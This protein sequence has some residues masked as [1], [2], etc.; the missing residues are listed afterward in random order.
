MLFSNTDFNFAHFTN[1]HFSHFEI[2]KKFWVNLG[3]ITK[4]LISLLNFHFGY[5]KGACFKYG[6]YFCSICL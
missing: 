1:F 3:K 2:E 4:W 5:L 6:P